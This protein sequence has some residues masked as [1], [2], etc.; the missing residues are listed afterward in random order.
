MAIRLTA[1]FIATIECAV[2]LYDVEGSR[3]AAG[4]DLRGALARQLEAT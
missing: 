4:Q 2:A 1:R 3:R